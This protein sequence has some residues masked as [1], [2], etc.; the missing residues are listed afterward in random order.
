MKPRMVDAIWV[1]FRWYRDWFR[2]DESATDSFRLHFSQ[3]MLS[4]VGSRTVAWR[5][6]VDRGVKIPAG[7]KPDESGQAGDN[8][9]N[10]RHVT[11][12]LQNGRKEI[13]ADVLSCMGSLISNDPTVLHER[14]NRPFV[15]HAERVH[16]MEAGHPIHDAQKPGSNRAERELVHL[17]RRWDDGGT[18]QMKDGWVEIKFNTSRIDLARCLK[19]L[20]GL[21][22]IS[23]M[24]WSPTV[25]LG[26]PVALL[27]V[28]E[29]DFTLSRFRRWSAIGH[30]STA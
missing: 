30:A 24:R 3:H 28:N 21:V 17:R 26:T 20:F 18:A 15:T 2:L 7:C 16:A 22:S 9:P 8:Q 29:L 10:P 5:V 19:L 25:A 4:I 14:V 13:G 27:A 23:A 6:V 12:L 11:H 1:T